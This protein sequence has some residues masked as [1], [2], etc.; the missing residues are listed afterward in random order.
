MPRRKASVS[1]SMAGRKKGSDQKSKK[2]SLGDSN[3][4]MLEQIDDE[5]DSNSF[6]ETIESAGNLN[7]LIFLGRMEESVQIGNFSFVLT[8]LSGGQQKDIVKSLMV[9]DEE[10]R[11]MHVRDLTLAAA[12][13][14]IN[15]VPFDELC[16]DDSLI[17]R[18][19]I[20]QSLQNNILDVL[21][22]KYNDMTKTA[23]SIHKESTEEQLKK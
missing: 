15:D 8:T 22:E 17:N 9:L 18:C 21:F 5:P 7:D 11:L 23:M 19:E 16:E 6:S 13:I 14:S 10:E 20:L 12:L 1:H 3:D 4:D 2:Q